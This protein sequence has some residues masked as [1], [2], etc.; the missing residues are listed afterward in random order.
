MLNSIYGIMPEQL[1]AFLSSEYPAYRSQQLLKW[2][3]EKKVFDPSKMTD[4][5]A[6]MQ[7]YLSQAFDFSMPQIVQTLKSMDGSQKFRLLL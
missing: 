3:Y 7:S 6:T 4:L 2:I 5:P 1:S